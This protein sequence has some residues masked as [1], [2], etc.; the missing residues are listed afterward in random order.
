MRL[1][2][3]SLQLYGFHSNCQCLYFVSVFADLSGKARC[4]TVIWMV[5]MKHLRQTTQCPQGNVCM[6]ALELIHTTH[7]GE[8]SMT[9]R[10][11]AEV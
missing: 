6:V 2:L 4:A 9:H 11:T 3:E 7:C 5:L 1:I 10:D 8:K